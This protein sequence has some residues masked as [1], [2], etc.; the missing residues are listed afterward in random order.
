VARG[1]CHDFPEVSENKGTVD[2]RLGTPLDKGRERRLEAAVEAAF[3][4]SE[5]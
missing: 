1:Q 5:L 2:E 3:H 4:H